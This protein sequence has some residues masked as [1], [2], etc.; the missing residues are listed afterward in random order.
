MMQLSVM[1]ISVWF[2]CLPRGQ[3]NLMACS[4]KHPIL[5]P[6]WCMVSRLEQFSLSG[7]FW[8]VLLCHQLC[9]HCFLDLRESTSSS[10]WSMMM[11]WKHGLWWH[12]PSHCSHAFIWPSFVLEIFLCRSCV[13]FISPDDDD[14]LAWIYS[15][16]QEEDRLQITIHLLPTCAGR[17][18]LHFLLDTIHHTQLISGERCLHSAGDKNNEHIPCQ[19]QNLILKLKAF[20]EMYAYRITPLPHFSNHQRFSSLISQLELLWFHSFFFCYNLFWYVNI[21]VKLLNDIL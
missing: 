10:S 3:P 11:M 17:W 4:S 1:S 9:S 8:C 13:A 14:L 21:K 15:A 19:K 18:L 2:D 16:N 20:H 5:C 7:T 12:R 6:K